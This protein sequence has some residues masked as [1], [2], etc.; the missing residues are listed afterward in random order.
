MKKLLLN[1][2]PMLLLIFAFT[3]V[4]ATTNYD[5]VKEWGQL[6][7]FLFCVGAGWIIGCIASCYQNMIEYFYS[8]RPDKHIYS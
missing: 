8:H 6:R 4:V 5:L 1:K 3:L 7:C 2:M